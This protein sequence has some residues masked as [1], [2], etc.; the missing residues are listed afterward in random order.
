MTALPLSVMPFFGKTL[1]SNFNDIFYHNLIMVKNWYISFKA[2]YRNTA[3]P[4]IC[5]I[6]RPKETQEKPKISRFRAFQID[7]GRWVPVVFAVTLALITRSL[8]LFGESG[9]YGSEVSVEVMVL[10]GTTK[11]LETRLRIKGKRGKITEY[12][13]FLVHIPWVIAKD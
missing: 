8:W 11:L 5:A 6:D 1:P 3:I 12:R 10:S 13:R 2:L 4:L 9:L 7:L